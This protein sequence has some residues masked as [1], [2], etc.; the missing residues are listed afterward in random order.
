MSVLTA[1]YR[2][3]LNMPETWQVFSIFKLANDIVEI[4]GSLEPDSTEH[5]RYSDGQNSIHLPAI[6]SLSDAIN[7]LIEP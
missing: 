2:S 5:L 1:Y 6:K 7:I 4:K 3:R